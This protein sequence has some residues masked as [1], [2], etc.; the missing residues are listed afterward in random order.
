MNKKQKI[1]EEKKEE[2]E[3]DENKKK[4]IEKWT[5]DEVADWLK[6]FG[7]LKVYVDTFKNE[8]I[9]GFSLLK[10]DETRLKELGMKKMG[11]RDQFLEALKN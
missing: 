5:I 4:I 8:E 10:M 11:H 3:I 6:K 1:E 2:K 9:N 7:D